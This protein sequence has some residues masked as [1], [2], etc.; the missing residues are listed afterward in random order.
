MNNDYRYPPG[1]SYAP[2]QFGVRP[3]AALSV[4]FLTQAFMWMFLGL[5][6]SAFVAFLVENNLGLA[7]DGAQPVAA[8]DHR[9]DGHRQSVCRSPS[10][11]S[12][13][14]SRWGSSSSTPRSTA[15]PSA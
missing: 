8:A 13:P 9:R 4:V 11:G 10:G 2:E 6:L 15:S 1:G 7:A 14:P 12:T 5:L 3:A